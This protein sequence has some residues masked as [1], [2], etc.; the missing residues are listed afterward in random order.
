MAPH[1][2]VMAAVR[3]TLTG[4]GKHRGLAA[5][6][7]RLR[8]TQVDIAPLL[9]LRIVRDRA[10]RDGLEPRQAVVSVVRE[11]ARRLDPTDRLIADAALSL[12]LLRDDPPAGIDIDHLYAPELGARR[13]YLAAH[14][15]TLHEFLGGTTIP[16]APTARTLRAGPERRAF[17]ALAE[18][19]AADPEPAPP[20]PRAAIG[21]VTVLGAA[22]IDHH[23]TT[24]LIP[25][26]DGRPARGRFTRHIGGKGLNRAVA[27]ARLGFRV[28]LIA[29]VGDDDAGRQ[30][31]H[32]LRAA[33][34]DTELVK[35][36]PNEPTPVAAVIVTGSGAN[37]TIGDMDQAVHLR[38]ED[39]D[40]PAARSAILE[41]DA[42]LVTFEQPLDVIRRALRLLRDVADRP[43]LLVHPTPPLDTP[44][45]LYE[46]FRRIDY[47]IGSRAELRGLL[48]TRPDSDAEPDLARQL[49][50]LGIDTV[51]RVEGLECQVRA[52]DETV[53][54]IPRLDAAQLH[55]S[56]G[57]RAAFMA[58]LTR[59]LVTRGDPAEFADFY[60]ATAAMTATQS[61]GDI[62][63]AMPEAAEIDRIVKFDR[64]AN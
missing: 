26:A 35:I 41:A 25:T 58:A 24:D 14:W 45:Y 50:A 12:G 30:I 33:G 57:A 28:R 40:T 61:F 43:W 46:Y 18:L 60:W 8:N 1:D 44:Q 53:I 22:V 63:E 29:A 32:Q 39:L 23:Y 54:D 31:L 10:D 36:V 64:T 2:S 47:V 21:V 7:D 38:P 37:A 16:N 3:N 6:A 5:G 48:T 13:E 17:T 4:L 27:A 15:H 59:R 20:E 51:C 11:T 19:L 34:V 56:I 42:V 62:A 49:L 55:E 9:D 52:A